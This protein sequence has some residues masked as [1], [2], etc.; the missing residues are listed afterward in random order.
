MSMQMRQNKEKLLA[1]TDWNWEM[2]K[3]NII[4]DVLNYN[5]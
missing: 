4:Q 1:M 3:E 2:S 5:K